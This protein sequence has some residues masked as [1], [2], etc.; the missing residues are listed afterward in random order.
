MLALLTDHGSLRLG[1]TPDPMPAPHEAL[2]RVQ[3]FSLNH[4]EVTHGLPATPDGVVPGWEAAGVIERAAMD[5]S[6]PPAGTPVVTLG[7]SGGWARFRAVPTAGLAVVPSGADPAAMSTIP[8]AATSALRALHRLGPVLGRTVL[9]TGASGAV[10]RYAVQLA[11]MAGAHV[12]AATRGGVAPGAHEVVT[13]AGE[14]SGLVHGV[15]ETV[16]GRHLVDAFARVVPGGTLVSV[17]R[18]DT[19][20]TV[21][22]FG[23]FGGD[24]GRHDRSLVSFYLADC[25]D[26]APDMTW[27]AGLVADGTLTAPVDHRADWRDVADALAHGRGRI[28]LDVT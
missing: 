2:V 3:A 16:G 10:G 11:R 26:L 14:Y 22:P 19:T 20:D 27:L 12:V 5:G 13:A 17:G 7:A 6:G 8:V 24:G 9:V 18:T 1:E 28:V 4:G 15:L 25:I 23:A 21:F